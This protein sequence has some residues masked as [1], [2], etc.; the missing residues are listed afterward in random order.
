[1]VQLRCEECPFKGRTIG[2]S[3]PIDA[4]IV[5]VGESP[6]NRELREGKPFVGDSGKILWS[7]IP[8]ELHSE[9]F[10]TNALQCM[11]LK[12]KKQSLIGQATKACNERLIAEIKQ[13]PRKLIIALGNSAMWSLTGNYGLKI[14]QERG[15]IF[16]SELCEYGIMPII[17]PAAIM[18]GTGTINQFRSDMKYA[19]HIGKGGSKKKTISPKIVIV[20]EDISLEMATHK[21][22]QNFKYVAADTETTGLNCQT[23]EILCLGLAVESEEVFVIP[24]ELCNDPILKTFLESPNTKFIWHNG[25]FDIQF[26][27]REGIE[28]RVDEDTMLLNY[29]LDEQGGI[30]DLETVGGSLLG[31]PNYKSMLKPYLPKKSDSYALVP[32]PVLYEYLGYDV[33]NTLQ[34]WNVLRDRVRKDPHLEKLYTKILIPAANLLAWV[35]SNGMMLDTHQLEENDIRLSGEIEA[36]I[37]VLWD[38]SETEINPSSPA[39]VAT[40]LFDKL[41]LPKIKGRSTD[42]EVLDKLP[43]HPVVAAIKKHRK[44]IKAR[45]TYV[46]SFRNKM[47]STGRVHTTFN[48]HGTRTGRLSSN[49]PPFQTIPRDPKIRSMVRARKGYKL[50]EIDLNQAELRCLAALSGDPDLCA[51]YNDPDHPGLHHEVSVTLFGSDYTNEDKMKA[52]AVNF[53]IMYGREARSLAEAHELPVKEAQRWIDG[54]F[55]RFPIAAN[56][57]N[58]CRNTPQKKQT[59]TTCYGRKKRHGLITRGNLHHLKNEAANFPHQSIASDINLECAINMQ[60]FLTDNDS[61]VINLIHDSILIEYPDRPQTEH[62]VISQMIQEMQQVPIRV[63]LR[64]VPFIAE[65]KS[66]TH[67]GYLEEYLI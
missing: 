59:I 24:Q 41:G 25:K 50:A 38:I 9:I 63:G 8:E 17:H 60:P 64:R 20:G 66:G 45:S 27:N 10:V 12:S 14:T 49:R 4:E 21:L 56:F 6:G 5:I 57:I 30:H 53:G 37:K 46:N 55:G 43:N 32:K 18:H 40:L 2:S 42:I 15:L 1:M 13:H 16:N 61:I 19:L 33:S 47:R 62:H 26:W 34:I 23:D 3:G 35:E 39:Q 7:C 31:A 65:A 58:T 29:A 44:A 22:Q 51:I 54:W 67:W 36:A 11:P 48:I 52:K 28:A